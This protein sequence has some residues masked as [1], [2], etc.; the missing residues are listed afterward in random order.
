MSILL[1]LRSGIF[2]GMTDSGSSQLEIIKMTDEEED[3]I[4]RMYRLVGQ[5]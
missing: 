4:F 1:L 3:L 2:C 5:R